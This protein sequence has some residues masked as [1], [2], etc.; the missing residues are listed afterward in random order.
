MY[1]YTLFLLLHAVSI[2]CLIVT[3][4]Y[5]EFGLLVF[6][7]VSWCYLSTATLFRYFGI[8]LLFEDLL[9]VV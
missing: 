1:C 8:V 3:E 6:L 2:W 4:K 9:K 7:K 5:V